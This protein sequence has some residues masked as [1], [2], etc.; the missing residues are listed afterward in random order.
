MNEVD[1]VHGGSAGK[2][3][4]GDAGFFQR[5][6][7]RFGNDAADQHGDIVHPFLAKQFHQLRTERVVRAERID[8]PMTSTS[9]CTAAD[10]IISGVCRKPV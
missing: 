6:D 8:R 4:F 7:V 5:G 2:K 3:N 9:S 10:A 1:D